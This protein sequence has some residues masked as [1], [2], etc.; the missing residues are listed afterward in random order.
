MEQA[1]R[2][3]LSSGWTT[4]GRSRGGRRPESRGDH[5]VKRPH[6]RAP[7]AISRAADVGVEQLQSGSST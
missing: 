2:R 5:K 6:E 7:V 3:K 4:A 1:L